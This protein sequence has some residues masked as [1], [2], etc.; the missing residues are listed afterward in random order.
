MPNA[1]REN[2][3]MTMNPDDPMHTYNEEVLDLLDTLD[4][5]RRH[6]S[7][8]RA[9]VDAARGDA[10]APPSAAG[11]DDDVPPPAANPAP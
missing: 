3:P 2:A 5:N 1:A 8:S 11:A 9:D 10:L 7:I 4:N 6:R